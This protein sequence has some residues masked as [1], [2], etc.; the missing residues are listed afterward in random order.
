LLLALQ[1]G[2][3]HVLEPFLLRP[4]EGCFASL[5][6]TAAKAVSGIEGAMH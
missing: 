2:L 6:S 1:Q 3:R 5:Q 4:L